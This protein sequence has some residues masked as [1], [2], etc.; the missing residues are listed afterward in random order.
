MLISAIGRKSN[1]RSTCARERGVTLVELLVVLAIIAMIAGVVV[2]NAPPVQ[3][4]AR[5]AGEQLAARLELAAEHA[6]TAGT[7]IGFEPSDSGYRFLEYDRGG[8]RT[9]SSKR[10]S[11]FSYPAGL[12]VELTFEEA[13]RKNEPERRQ[14]KEDDKPNPRV[15]FYPTGETTP[16]SITFRAQRES[17]KV[18]LDD[19][20]QAQISRGDNDR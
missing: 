11:D 15:W 2:L 18:T 3:N 14:T 5:R 17:L 7:I 4:D 19:A 20:G 9:I 10:F 13:V 8:W 6:I 12:A 16:L 1:R